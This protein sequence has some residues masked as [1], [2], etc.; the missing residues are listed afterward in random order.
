MPFGRVIAA[1]VVCLTTVAAQAVTWQ[2]ASQLYEAQ[3]WEAARDAFASIATTSDDDQVAAAAQF[4]VAECRMQ[5]DDFGRAQHELEMLLA[6][7]EPDQTPANVLFRAGEAARLAG[8]DR[9]GR[10][11]LREFVGRHPD[12]PYAS[13]AYEHLAAMGAAARDYHGAARDYRRALNLA[14]DPQHAGD[15]R[16]ALVRA[17]AELGQTDAALS[18]AE[19]LLADAV[20]AG[21][22]ALL[23]IGQTLYDAQQYDAAL[24]AFRNVFL[25]YAER[26]EAARAR[27][28]AGWALLKLHRTDEVA[29]VLAPLSDDRLH[30]HPVAV[31]RGM[32]AYAQGRYAAA[33]RLLSTEAELAIDRGSC[34]FY[35]GESARRSGQLTRARECFERVVAADSNGPWA[36]DALWGLAQIAAAQGDPDQASRRLEQLTRQHPGSRYAAASTNASALRSTLALKEA[37]GFLRDGRHDAALASFAEVASAPDA[38]PDIR[39][40]ALWQAGRLQQRLHL[41]EEA[42]GSFQTLLAD[43]PRH[44]RAADT[45]LAL[46]KLTADRGDRAAASAQFTQICN[47]FPQSRQALEAAYWLAADRA[48]ERD[49]DQARHWAGWL[50]DELQRRRSQT[51]AETVPEDEQAKQRA[52]LLEHHAQLLLAQVD[53]EAGRWTAAAERLNR[54]LAADDLGNLTLPAEF[55]LAECNYRLGH[56]AD[57]QQQYATLAG[58]TANMNAGWAGMCRLR[59]AQIS[60]H[61]RQWHD[62]LMQLDRLRTEHPDFPLAAD[63]D[64]LEGRT[65]AARGQMSAA[66]T[67]YAKVLASDRRKEPIAA[68]AQWMIGETYFHQRNYQQARRAYRRVIDE[69]QHPLW[70]T[71]AALQI[72]K[73]WELEGRWEKARE[74]YA[75]A[76]TPTDADVTPA[77]QKLLKQ[78]AARRAWVEQHLR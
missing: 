10:E 33:Y 7:S 26:D 23:E 60:A 74:I 77:Q 53:A 72:G 68:Q 48:D 42:A 40:E 15:I 11:R 37:L 30:A 1:V 44:A 17:L 3:D 21:A 54:M 2:E 20:D 52:R 41:T 22:E 6:T 67:A 46:A 9:L 59:L 70:Q 39:G 5:L 47:D 16:L 49:S 24:G 27:V 61:R 28:A 45:R 38:D 56:W 36:D 76:P 29:V 55:W 64:Y 65:Y 63:A 73:C 31:L 66:R 32:T 69:H 25:R 62:V 57:A 58:R 78:L 50:L 51:S 14:T 43:R 4:Y 18:V 34:Q 35:A 19:P 71:H 8:D 12:H 13:Y 75:A